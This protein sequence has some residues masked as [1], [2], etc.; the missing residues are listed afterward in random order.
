MAMKNKVAGLH[1]CNVTVRYYNTDTRAF[2][3]VGLWIVTSG[4]SLPIALKKAQTFLK[5]NRDEYQKAQ[6]RKVEYKGTIDA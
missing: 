3:T 1:L 5:H 4:E 6:I 2:F